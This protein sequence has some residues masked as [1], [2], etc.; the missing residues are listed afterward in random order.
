MIAS[1]GMLDFLA[2]EAGLLYGGGD[3]DWLV[4]LPRADRVRILGYMHARKDERMGM[5][6]VAGVQATDLIHFGNHGPDPLREPV[7]RYDEQ[8]RRR[9]K[10]RH[11]RR[12]TGSTRRRLGITRAIC[13]SWTHPV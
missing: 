2:V 11:D 13:G 1:G 6:S 9:G 10:L 3:L 4:D 8:R 5:L 7:A 12:G